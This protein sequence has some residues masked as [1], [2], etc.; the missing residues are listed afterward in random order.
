M[1][2]EKR[3]ARDALV[4]TP[5]WETD[6]AAEGRLPVAGEPEGTEFLPPP[7][8]ADMRLAVEPRCCV[9]LRPPPWDLRVG[10]PV[11]FCARLMGGGN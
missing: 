11:R 6:T 1:V 2:S 3:S 4:R 10:P 9:E 7:P 5:P 8:A